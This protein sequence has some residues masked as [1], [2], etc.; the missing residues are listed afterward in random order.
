MSTRGLWL[1]LLLLWVGCRPL[2]PS[3]MPRDP[4]QA[5]VTLSNVAR[6]ATF[7]L[8]GR[9]R[10]NL[11]GV[12]LDLGLT[13]TAQQDGG[14]RLDV[15]LPFGG[16][17]LSIV[18]DDDGGVLCRTIKNDVVYFSADADGLAQ[19]LAG[20]WAHA[21]SL[22]D[23]FTGKLPPGID[24][25]AQWE[26]R[27]SRHML[28]LA[29]PDEKRALFDTHQR[30]A[31]LRQMLLVRADGSVLASATW[32]DWAEMEGYWFPRRIALRFFGKFA[33]IDVEIRSLDTVREIDPATFDASPP[34]TYRPFED[35]F[36][37]EEG[38]SATASH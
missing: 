9:L 6:P 32:N 31:M 15:A 8:S 23:L 30:P 34:D 10:T 22:V 33:N 2:P 29:L 26:R 25:D 18:L 37:S 14:A 5:M 1:V 3:G 7:I 4:G 24:T 36:G 20:S 12:D 17:A 28:S 27:D 16:Y 13:L 19:G 21:A 38:S 35:L 11:A